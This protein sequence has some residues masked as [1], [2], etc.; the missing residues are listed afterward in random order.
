MESFKEHIAKLTWRFLPLTQGESAIVDVSDF[1]ALNKNH[2]HAAWNKPTQSYYAV[3]GSSVHEEFGDKQY[4]IR[5]HRYLLGLG[6]GDRRKGDHENCDTLDNRRDNIRHATHGQNQHNK[7]L[8][9]NSVT[10]YKGVTKRKGYNRWRAQIVFEGE[11]IRIGEFRDPL[12]A[13]KAYCAMAA[14][15]FGKFARFS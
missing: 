12:E 5:M 2:W 10:G 15:L 8:Q 3:R 7:R 11:N 13:H 6:K 1:D 4:T 9:R 14:K